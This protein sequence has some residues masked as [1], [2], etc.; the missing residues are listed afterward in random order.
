M[1]YY[2]KSQISI[3]DTEQ[4]LKLFTVLS[5]ISGVSEREITRS[6]KLIEDL[7]IDSF[8]MLDL[9][10]N[11]ETAF[12][13]KKVSDEKLREIRTVGDL[14]DAIAKNLKH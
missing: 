3:L 10:Y 13:I 9:A 8:S 1:Q 14:S 7:G 6:S 2:K 12:C 4:E 11:L 5:T